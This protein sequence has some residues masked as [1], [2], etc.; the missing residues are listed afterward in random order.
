[1]ADAGPPGGA[2]GSRGGGSEQEVVEV[3][4]RALDVDRARLSRRMRCCPANSVGSSKALFGVPCPCRKDTGHLAAALPRSLLTQT[5]QAIQ[6][7]GSLRSR[8]AAR[9]LALRHP[10]TQTDV[11]A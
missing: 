8:A 2:A 4:A 7:A 5:I 3:T 9:L 6:E 10:L 11:A 1:M